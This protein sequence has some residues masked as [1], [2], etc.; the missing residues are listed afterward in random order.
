[1][2]NLPANIDKLYDITKG[3]LFFEKNAGFFGPLL[4]KLEFKWTRDHGI[5]TA[6]ISDDTLYWNPD[7]F[8]KI[9]QKTRVT[10]LAHEIKHNADLD[11]VRQGNRD[12]DLWNQ[13]CDHAINLFLKEHGYYM[14]GFPYLM[15]PKYKG[16]AKEDI[17]DDLLKQQKKGGSGTKPNPLGRDV[18]PI[19]KDK[20]PAM[21]AN[22]VGAVQTARMSGKPG[23]IP[24]DTALVLDRFLNPKLPWN[25][26]L[27]N[28]FNALVQDSRSYARPS[29][30]YEDVIM[31]SML[32]REG[33][34]HLM[35]FLDISGSTTDSQIEQSN[36]EVKHIQEDLEPERL[37][38]VT[39][40]HGIRDVFEFERG[41]SYPGISVHGRGGTNLEPVYAYAKKHEATAM[42]ILTDLELDFPPDPGIPIVFVVVDNPGETAPYG[43]TI[44]MDVDG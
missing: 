18:L 22:I 3:K 10:V 11:G 41:E 23:D 4:C 30:R 16:W 39:F 35:Y 20:I 31:P 43:V 33:L 14:D 28:F 19:P 36:A 7:F 32:G 5:D 24:G 12:P 26:I 8:M 34:E 25:Q 27:F 1:M 15:D 44:H 38:M 42:V 40:D 37:T 9:D 29:R 17:Y 2:K 21:V 13:A 6:A